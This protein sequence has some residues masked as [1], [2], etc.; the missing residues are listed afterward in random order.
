[1]DVSFNRYRRHRNISFSIPKKKIKKI[2]KS[3][4]SQNL[5]NTPKKTPIKLSPFL[6]QNVSEEKETSKTESDTEY[7]SSDKSYV[8]PEFSE[9]YR[10][11]EKLDRTKTQDENIDS[12]NNDEDVK[13]ITDI[14]KSENSEEILNMGILN[15][16]KDFENIYRY[17]KESELLVFV[18]DDL[19]DNNNVIKKWFKKVD[20]PRKQEL[21]ML[22]IKFISRLKNEME[23]W[24]MKISNNMKIK[25]KIDYL[26]IVF[27]DD[28]ILPNVLYKKMIIYNS[29]LFIP[30]K[31]YG[32]KKIEYKIR[33]FC[34]LMEELGASTI[35]IEFIKKSVRTNNLSLNTNVNNKNITEVVGTLGFQ[36]KNSE[37]NE[38][39]QKYVLNY[40]TNT[41]ITL[42]QMY[43]EKKIRDGYYIITKWNYSSNLELQYIVAS[44]CQHYIKNYSTNFN[45]YENL[46]IDKKLFNSLKVYGI[47]YGLNIEKQIDEINQT[48]I[49][50]NVIFMDDEYCFDNITGYNVNLDQNGFVFL[51]KS[52]QNQDFEKV[53]IYKIFEFIKS[54]LDNSIKNKNKKHY[55]IMKTKLKLLESN[56]SVDILVKLLLNYF[57]KYS[58]WVHVVNFKNIL[59]MNTKTYDKLGYIL[60]TN[61]YIKNNYDIYKYIIEILKNLTNNYDNYFIDFENNNL[62][63]YN[64]II[65]ELKLN[66]YNMSKLDLMINRVNNFKTEFLTFK[67]IMN[68][69]N[70]HNKIYYYLEYIIPYIIKKFDNDEGINYSHIIYYQIN[71]DEKL[72][73]FYKSRKERN[74]KLKIIIDNLYQN[75]Q[76]NQDTN[77]VNLNIIDKIKKYTNLNNIEEIKNKYTSEELLDIMINYDINMDFKKIIPDIYG[78]KLLRKQIKY[79]NLISNKQNIINFYNNLLDLM[80]QIYDVKNKIK[81]LEELVNDYNN[82]INKNYYEIYDIIKNLLLVSK[83]SV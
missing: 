22:P 79:G 70:N 40:S 78:Y 83:V 1:M 63:Y 30:L 12:F 9:E 47:N 67:D 62:Y 75:Y 39:E 58:R 7:K 4:I 2:N 82:L 21:L 52:I 24:N 27:N 44:R 76:D 48:I 57:D 71:C 43:V 73:L 50:T 32:L 34:Q 69:F 80:L 59:L 74:T 26:K 10:P 33:G 18:N 31:D 53:G 17:F 35:E 68:N 61:N 65:N 36:L 5:P 23:M 3:P 11:G 15:N 42:N 51:M 29:L 64:S 55:E 16:I 41:N 66:N 19:L 60:V 37:D 13:D 72:D 8:G 45:L 25:K 49:K 6:S 46:G 28:E 81:Y 77:K 38:N 56:F 14:K 54:H 20:K